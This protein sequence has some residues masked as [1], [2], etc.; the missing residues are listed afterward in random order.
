VS[1]KSQF[2]LN[3]G[4]LIIVPITMQ[5]RAAGIARGPGQAAADRGP[6]DAVPRQDP[7]FRPALDRE[8]PDR[9]GRAAARL[10]RRVRLP[11]RTPLSLP[12]GLFWPERSQGPLWPVGGHKSHRNGVACPRAA[13]WL[14][15]APPGC[16]AAPPGCP[17]E[18]WGTGT[19]NLGNAPDPERGGTAIPSHY[20]ER[21]GPGRHPRPRPG[22]ENYSCAPSRA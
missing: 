12:Q 9:L 5:S 14:P 4:E 8:F 15:D 2:G 19:Q 22:R 3:A 7:G 20:K 16:P 6:R 18:N 17:T 11:A 1:R 13:V 10:R 21:G